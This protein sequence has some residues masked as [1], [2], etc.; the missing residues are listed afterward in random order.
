MLVR[1]TRERDAP[2]PDDFGRTFAASTG[3]ALIPLSAALAVLYLVFTVG[4]LRLI[5]PPNDLRMAAAALLTAVL[6]GALAVLLHSRRPLAH[7]NPVAMGVGVVVLANSLLH[8][9]LLG[10]VRQ[11]TNLMLIV[12]AAGLFFASLPWLAG[13]VV[14]IAVAWGG[15]VSRLGVPEPVWMH[16]AFGLATAA[17]I[18]GVAFTVRRSIFRRWY[19]AHRAQEKQRRILEANLKTLADNVQDIIFRVELAPEP[20]LTFINRSVEQVVGY[21][22]EAFYA[23][24][25]L[26]IRLLHR[27]DRKRLLRQLSDRFSHWEGPHELRW[28]TR[29][30]D[31]L[32]LEL[33][34][35]PIFDHGR[36][37]AA[38]GIARDVSQRRAVEQRVQAR[39]RWLRLALEAAHT[40]IWEIDLQT[41]SMIWSESAERLFGS[42]LGA[43]PATLD[44]YLA[45]VHPVDRMRVRETLTSRTEAL[46]SEHRIV[47][48]DGSIR[49]YVARGQ[50]RTAGNGAR[51]ACVLGSLHDITEAKDLEAKLREA[52]D[53]AEEANRLKTAILS[54]MSHEIRTPL[55]TI[56][57]YAEL[58]GRGMV[59][60]DAARF[61]QVI[62]EAGSRLLATLSNMIDLARLESGRFELQPTLHD[63]N[64]SIERVLVRTRP[65]AERKGVRVLFHPANAHWVYSDVRAEEHIL[66]NLLDNAVRFTDRG[67]I[68]VHVRMLFDRSTREP[69]VAVEVSDTGVGIH[70]SFLPNVF[71]D[72]RQ[73][74]E[75]L[76]RTYEGIGLGLP[77]ARR[78]ARAQGGD[79]DVASIA[80]RGTRAVVILRGVLTEARTA[81]PSGES[82]AHEHHILVVEDDPGC[83]RL[84]QEILVREGSVVWCDD[85]LQALDRARDEHFD[86]V[87]MDI[88]L[89]GQNGVEVLHRLRRMD[90]YRETPV[91]AVTAYAMKGDRERLMAEGFDGYVSKPFHPTEILE[92]VHRDEPAAH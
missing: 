47:H 11:T 78:L 55:T 10:D 63:A 27:E 90:A 12:A 73:E 9:L 52:R 36:I 51:G 85:A 16:Y 38:E 35:A 92:L 46:V 61:G 33:N 71:E 82:P 80:G 86:R 31:Y 19:R 43:F 58:L 26:V 17:L 72:Y 5:E 69:L 50:V 64:E 84:L 22:P 2:A 42:G 74:S 13:T 91:F 67:E 3:D 62:F 76:S 7:P 89:R 75:G 65:L 45:A 1:H 88:D 49:W 21:D 56:L 54:N 20:R 28:K 4:H 70:P 79:V 40:A 15:A 53:R 59:P 32:W 48:P 39:E 60:E 29:A 24:P 68:C 81:A 37:V 25:E 41:G 18:S 87:F 23:D 34:V 44:S 30:G 83:G 57:G 66:Q 8:L 77:V 6:F 14:L